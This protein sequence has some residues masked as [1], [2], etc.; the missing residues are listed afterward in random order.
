MKKSGSIFMGLLLTLTLVLGMGSVSFAAGSTT[1]YISDSSPSVGD[2]VTV[3][4][5]GSESSTI[6]VKYTSDI[7]SFDSCSVAGY[8]SEGNSI[9]FAAKSGDITFKAASDGRANVIVSSDTLT[10]SSASISVSG[11]AAAES[12]PAAEEPAAEEPAPEDT[13]DDAAAA[14][15]QPSGNGD[16]TVDGVDYVISERYRDS[17]VPAGFDRA[18]LEIHGKTYSEPVTDKITLLYL[19][20]AS[21]TSGSGV[22]YV[23]DQAADSVS[24]MYLFG[25]ESHY[26]IGL[27][28]DA[29]QFSELT[30]SSV[31]VGE[32]SYPAY[33]LLGSGNDFYY[34]Y[35]VNESMEEGWYS[36]REST[37]EVAAADTYALSLSTKTETVTDEP[38][39][40]EEDEP[41]K[42]S[43]L[44]KFNIENMRT[45][46]AV[47]VI[48][49]A[50]I[51]IFIINLYVFRRGDEDDDIWA[52]REDA[53]DEDDEDD[54]D[55]VK[56]AEK[57]GRRAS[58]EDKTHAAEPVN[59][60]KPIKEADSVKN[61][62]TVKESDY[63]GK[64]APSETATKMDGNQP[65]ELPTEEAIL[66]NALA[67]IMDDENEPPK[68]VAS[69]IDSLPKKK[70]N[71]NDG[72]SEIT[73]IDL[74]NL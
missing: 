29:S 40:P 56:V 31:S 30:E 63:V 65:E 57:P 34:I 6:T 1:L 11:S 23:Y 47:A 64:A 52:E 8:T 36:Y 46:I 54:E 26:V 22:F 50:I 14:P 35:G 33:Q 62:D 15:A 44:S 16:F 10:G 48:I 4:V 74:N 70:K 51:I 60:A 42:E 69:A 49:I 68:K 58:N 20:P 73:M 2:K 19:K 37:G 3:S 21:D 71:D 59:K 39:E 24:K 45:V 41:E 53:Y 25:S 32:E 27:S 17:E 7:I 66:K 13:S 5:S 72:N 43:F 18:T 67:G 9:T 61:A 28:G 55:D 38:D 12:E